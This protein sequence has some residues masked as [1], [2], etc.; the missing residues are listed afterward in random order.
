MR[1]LWGR[2]MKMEN[3]NSGKILITG[4]SSGIGAAFARALAVRQKNL[5]LIARRKE[6]LEN[7]ASELRK[8]HNID[9]E[10]LAT[11]LSESRDIDKVE[12]YIADNQALDMLINN[13][14][15]VTAGRFSRTSLEEQEAMVRLHVIAPIR[16]THAALPKM[17]ERGHGTII[18][19][20]SNA[21]FIPLPGSVTYSGTKA[22]LVAFSEALQSELKGTG[23]H[24]QALCPG[25]T[26]TEFHDRLPRFKSSSIPAPFWTNPEE[27]VAASLEAVKKNKVICIPG[28]MNRLLVAFAR[29]SLTSHLARMFVAKMLYRRR[30]N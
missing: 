12:K 28:L 5:M 16:L 22:F 1:D 18:N 27:V 13:A 3:Q 6:R 29:N 17:V 7:L 25:F 24:V 26:H 19:V 11:D 14:G 21:A 10:I 30:S 2:D 23:V 8:N 4:A 20:S 15:F 9:V